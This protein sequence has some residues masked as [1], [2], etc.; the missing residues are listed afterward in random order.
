MLGGYD[1]IFMTLC[2]LLFEIILNAE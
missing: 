2:L 1:I